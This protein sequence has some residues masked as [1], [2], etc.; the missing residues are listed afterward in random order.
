M[1]GR[2]I[3][4]AGFLLATAMDGMRAGART[5]G[6]ALADEGLLF[7]PEDVFFLTL[8][9][10]LDNPRCHRRDLVAQRQFLYARYSE[11][12]LP[13]I[14]QGNPTSVPLGC[15]H[16]HSQATEDARPD[17]VTAMGVSAGAA[18]GVAKV[19][20]QVGSYHADDFD[21]GD[22]VVCRI[23]DPSRA[24]L[25]SVAAGVVIDI[26]ARRTA[27][28]PPD[29]TAK[30]ESST[31]DSGSTCPPSTISAWP[32]TNEASALAR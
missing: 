23:A 5:I 12:D 27:H 7:D 19:A 18:T 25:L 10:L 16:E 3:G 6:A 21:P 20:H 14:W 9:V 22:I 26:G 17:L 31:S 29:V 32:V 11:L 24:P 8:E 2:E 4:K 28:S 30:S 13:E 15:G 1:R